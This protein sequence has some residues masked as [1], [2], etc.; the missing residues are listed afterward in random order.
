MKKRLIGITLTCILIL[1]SCSTPF[2]NYS[3]FSESE[4]IANPFEQSEDKS[5]GI[6]TLPPFDNNSFESTPSNSFDKYQEGGLQY[7]NYNIKGGSVIK[8]HGEPIEITFDADSSENRFDVEMGYMAFIDGVPQKLSLNGGEKNELVSLSHIPDTKT[9]ITL[10]L[11]PEV[12]YDA[13]DRML[14]LKI[15]TIFNPSYRPE[16]EYVGFG[17]AHSGQSFCEYDIEI[18]TPCT[19]IEALSESKEYE[20]IAITEK[21]KEEYKLGDSSEKKPTG[22]YIKDIKSKE[23]QLILN[24]GKAEAELMLYGKD[25]FTYNIFVYVNHKRVSF[26]Y[27]DYLSCDVKKGF[28]TSVPLEIKN[29]NAGDII[30]AVAIPINA[31]TGSMNCRKSVSIL[32]VK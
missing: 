26:N 25:E 9:R 2:D 18:S 10:T 13:A 28:I 7:S 1:C 14:K 27:C 12:P 8:Y 23:Q 6:E 19:N 5:S 3:S 32:I 11:V 16:G 29:I 17:N 24:N 15:I 4:V 21:T 31:D 30:Y 20:L 22:V